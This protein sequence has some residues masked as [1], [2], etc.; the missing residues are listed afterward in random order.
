MAD[1]AKRRISQMRRFLNRFVDG[2]PIR[3]SKK[4]DV[5]AILL[6]VLVLP[7]MRASFITEE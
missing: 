2:L 4:L 5:D 7:H 6:L 1:S 3:A